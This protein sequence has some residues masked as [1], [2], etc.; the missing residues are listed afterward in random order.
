MS[1]IFRQ[2]T[3]AVKAGVP[4]ATR[5]RPGRAQHPPRQAS[6]QGGERRLPGGEE[7]RGDRR[8]PRAR[9]AASLTVQVLLLGPHDLVSRGLAYCLGDRGAGDTV[10][11]GGDSVRQALARH[12]G[13]SSATPAFPQPA[14]TGTPKRRRTPTPHRTPYP[15][16]LLLRPPAWGGAQGHALTP[17]PG[18]KQRLVSPA[19]SGTAPGAPLPPPQ[20]SPPLRWSAGAGQAERDR[21]LQENG[22]A[23]L[24]LGAFRA[25]PGHVTGAPPRLLLP[26]LFLPFL[27]NARPPSL[28]EGRAGRCPRVT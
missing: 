17:S 5:P 19:G 23:R 16:R 22:G 24:L 7:R 26:P 13:G 11:G 14:G 2:G 10:L 27:F 15:H 12:L 1:G 20:L 21:Q 28:S 3:E 18:K 4:G 6:R 9:R 8:G 25:P